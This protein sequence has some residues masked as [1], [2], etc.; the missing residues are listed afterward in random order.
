MNEVLVEIF[1]NGEKSID[2]A[3]CQERSHPPSPPTPT[4]TSEPQVGKD[5]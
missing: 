2:A 5:V 1:V 3:D 4:G